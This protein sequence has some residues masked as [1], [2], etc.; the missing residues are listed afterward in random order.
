MFKNEVIPSLEGYET[1][2][3]DQAGQHL[4]LGEGDGPFIFAVQDQGGH[5]HLG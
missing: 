5:R 4:S 2:V 3:G 1:R